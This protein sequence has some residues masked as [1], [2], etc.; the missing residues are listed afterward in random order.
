M[1]DIVKFNGSVVVEL[2]SNGKKT[3][4]PPSKHPNGMLYKWNGMSLLDIDKNSLPLFPP[5]TFVHLQNKLQNAFPDAI[6]AG[7]GKVKSGRNDELSSLCGKLISE[8]KTVDEVIHDLIKFDKDNNDPPLF[9]DTNELRH[10]EA[11]TNALTF[12]TNHLNSIN[13]RRFRDQKEYEVPA[14]ATVGDDAKKVLETTRL[15]K[16]QRQG[17]Q[18]RVKERTSPVNSANKTMLCNCPFCEAK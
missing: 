8:N 3:T 16:S 10:S 1:T 7:F 6:S 4:L 5:F 9:T 13:Y 2:L 11:Y 12:Y 18:K 14:M 15:G 17:R